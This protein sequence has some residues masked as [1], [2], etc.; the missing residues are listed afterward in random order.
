MTKNY[1]MFVCQQHKTLQL[2]L[3]IPV[4][5]AYLLLQNG[6]TFLLYDKEFMLIYLTFEPNVQC[7]YFLSVP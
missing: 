3:G 2:L 5:S 1:A 4:L 7:F 6:L